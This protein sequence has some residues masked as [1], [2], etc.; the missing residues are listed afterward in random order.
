MN[1]LI[2]YIGKFELKSPQRYYIDKSYAQWKHNV[3]GKIL[4]IGG[5]RNER[6]TKNSVTLDISNN[7]NPDILASGYKLP[8]KDN[9]FD[10]IVSI[11][12]LEH[13]ERPPTFVDETYRI[14]KSDGAFFL[15]TRFIHEIHGEDYF[16]YTELSLRA[17]FK[18][19]KI[20][21]VEDEGSVFSVL[22]WF[23]EAIF[24][25]SYL[26]KILSLFYPLTEKID[27]HG[28]KRITLGYSVYGRK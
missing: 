20:A 18:K 25:Y 10:T 13:L 28:P 4:E 2:K 11:E 23:I 12:V 17:L 27:H 6:Y 16:R 19:F 22:L 3:K 5:G 15:T 8:F 24:P 26:K 9:V 21:N 1:P 7:F 14:L